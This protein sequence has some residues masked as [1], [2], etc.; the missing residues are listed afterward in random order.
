MAV[1]QRCKTDSCFSRSPVNSL[2]YYD[3]ITHDLSSSVSSLVSLNS[4]LSLRMSRSSPSLSVFKGE[5]LD[6]AVEC[7][8]FD[9]HDIKTIL[10]VRK[11][12]L[13]EVLKSRTEELKLLC[14]REGEMTGEVPPD[15]P[16]TG[17][18]APPTFKRRI[19][20]SFALNNRLIENFRANNEEDLTKLELECEIQNNITM[21]VL[22]LASDKT[23][24]RSVRKQ[25]KAAHERALLKL[26]D[27]Q[28]KLSVLKR[29]SQVVN[30]DKSSE[31]GETVSLKKED[32][33]LLYISSEQST[34]HETG[35]LIHE[36]CPIP[37]VSSVSTISPT[38][39]HVSVTA[40]PSSVPSSPE[41]HRQSSRESRRKNGVFLPGRSFQTSVSG[42]RKM[43][44]FSLPEQCCKS[45]SINLV[46]SC[47][48]LDVQQFSE[49]HSCNSQPSYSESGDILST[50][51]N[52]PCYRSELSTR[53]SVFPAVS[54]RINNQPFGSK[55][56]FIHSSRSRRDKNI[57]V[58]HDSFSE[59]EL[60]RPNRS[61]SSSFVPASNDYRN[62]LR[63]P[64]VV[65]S[66]RKYSGPCS[67]SD[68]N[69]ERKIKDL[70]EG[71]YREY[72]SSPNMINYSNDKL[73]NKNQWQSKTQKTLYNQLSQNNK[74]NSQVVIPMSEK[75]LTF[76]E[77]S[78]IETKPQCVQSNEEYF[79]TTK[80]A[81]YDNLLDFPKTSINYPSINKQLTG[82]QTCYHGKHFVFTNINN[83][84]K[85]TEATKTVSSIDCLINTKYDNTNFRPLKLSRKAV[86][87]SSV[88]S[89]QTNTSSVVPPSPVSFVQ[90]LPSS[91][92][93]PPSPMLFSQKASSSSVPSL[94]TESFLLA[95]PS[96]V[97]LLDR[98]P[99][100]TKVLSL[101]TVS[102]PQRMPPSAQPLSVENQINIQE[103]ISSTQN[104]LT[105]KGSSRAEKVNSFF[106]YK[107][108]ST[109]QNS[110]SRVRRFSHFHKSK[111]VNDES[112]PASSNKNYTRNTKIS[113]SH[114]HSSKFGYSAISRFFSLTKFRSNSNLEKTKMAA[115]HPIRYSSVNETELFKCSKPSNFGISNLC[116]SSSKP[117][118][119]DSCSTS[120]GKREINEMRQTLKT[121][122]IIIYVPE[123]ETTE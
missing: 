100:S 61:N 72:L 85:E 90:K 105:P 2:R 13:E 66:Y 38:G 102:C 37:R 36:D 118:H 47:S 75:I 27:L 119:S 48:H 86:S 91:L 108:S 18:E 58:L 107:N 84:R 69:R 57:F 97:S 67:L 39:L 55:I 52:E 24:N 4:T 30:V 71:D 106:S 43:S 54:T 120:V 14:L 7:T 121:P 114:G 33:G 116:D 122:K 103:S 88:P 65:Q 79:Q 104:A 56:H 45:K 74:T 70:Y 8:D 95:S 41:I 89:F 81:S 50:N 92:T 53:T 117:Q 109:E 10:K 17:S 32:N 93:V 22:K 35:N 73:S 76:A 9:K 59:S 12:A 29:Q 26:K 21:A 123:E 111:T 94:E 5:V 113:T 63:V 112:V 42:Q 98:E 16:L 115:T 80:Q 11:E 87:F 82:S 25:R 3:H 19:R 60:C 110:S 99:S 64:N 44:L 28:Q 23:V 62:F 77:R 40:N 31:E 15:F 51:T 49:M 34:E 96:P 6:K 101:Q 1:A 78:V 46:S 68:G 83:C 20:T